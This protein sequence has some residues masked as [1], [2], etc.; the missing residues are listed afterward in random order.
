MFRRDYSK[1]CRIFTKENDT[2]E[3]SGSIIKYVPLFDVN[4]NSLGLNALGFYEYGYKLK[5]VSR[6]EKFVK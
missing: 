5:L 1:Q 4:R 6:Y 2:F 3:Y